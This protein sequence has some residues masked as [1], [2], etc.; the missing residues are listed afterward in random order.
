MNV[1]IAL[2]TALT[3]T[4]FTVLSDYPAINRYVLNA[5]IKVKSILGFKLFHCRACQT[6]WTYMITTELLNPDLVNLLLNVPIGLALFY[7]QKYH[8]NEDINS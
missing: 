7:I 1:L 2:L 8:Q 6:F 5:G 4:R 3:L